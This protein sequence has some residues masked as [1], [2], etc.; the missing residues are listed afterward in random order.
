[1]LSFSRSVSEPERTWGGSGMEFLW[2]REEELEDGDDLPSL[3]EAILSSCYED[4][5]GHLT[6]KKAEKAHTSLLRWAKLRA[7]WRTD[8]PEDPAEILSLIV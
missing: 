6:E 7:R 2:L 5:H 8:S 4:S 3:L 1:M